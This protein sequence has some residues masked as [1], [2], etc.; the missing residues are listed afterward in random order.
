MMS[1]D[2]PEGETIYLDTNV[3]IYLVEGEPRFRE[4]LKELFVAI[5]Q[6]VIF[7]VTSELT[8]AEVMVEPI[9]SKRSDIAA[10]YTELLSGSGPLEVRPVDRGTLLKSA[11]IRAMFG[12]RIFD[13]VHVA[14]AS[15]AQCDSIL[16]EDRGLGVPPPLQHLT[17]SALKGNA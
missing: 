12:G 8:L 6:E 14:T 17:L 2:T 15:L 16:S 5:D 3:F 7:A 1:I 4:L 9:A 10:T 13:A 11:E